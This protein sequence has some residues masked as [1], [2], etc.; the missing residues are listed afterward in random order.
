VEILRDVPKG[1]RA[2]VQRRLFVTSD[3]PQPGAWHWFGPRRVEYRPATWWQPGTT[4]TVRMALGGLPLGHGGYGDTDRTATA[5]ISS[6][7]VEL[8]IT[9]QPQQM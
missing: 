8:R 9:N 4:L 6:D 3:P 5:R 2:A 1:L 7:R